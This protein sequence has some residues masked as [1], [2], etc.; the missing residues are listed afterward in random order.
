MTAPCSGDASGGSGA[1][2]T[3]PFLFLLGGLC[4]VCFRQ[5]EEPKWSPQWARTHRCPRSVRQ[6]GGASGPTA[7][8][9]RGAGAGRQPAAGRPFGGPRDCCRVPP[10]RL[11]RLRW[12]RG[13]VTRPHTS[14]DEPSR[15]GRGAAGRQGRAGAHL[16]DD[17][18]LLGGAPVLHAHR[19]P[20]L[21]RG[22]LLGEERAVLWG[23][24]R[25]WSGPGLLRPTGWHRPTRH[26]SHGSARPPS[27]VARGGHTWA[28][29]TVELAGH[30]C[31]R[32]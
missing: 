24:Q 2:C 3:G 6:R 28:C 17:G 14:L 15:E 23:G 22:Q 13:R 8:R 29:C 32:V 31:G 4:P 21:E 11:A 10:G 7:V 25:R 16:Q 30:V 27:D 18:Q 1:V 9:V 5:A 20:H 26:A 12:W 19:Q